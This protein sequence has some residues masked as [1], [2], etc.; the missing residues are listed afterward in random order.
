MMTIHHELRNE[1]YDNIP[2]KKELSLVYS[3]IP[4]ENLDELKILICQAISIYG[5]DCSLNWIDTSKVTDMSSLFSDFSEKY[6]IFNNKI[7]F[8]MFTGDISCWNVSNVKNFKKMF[9]GNKFFN[10]PLSWNMENAEDTS[11]MFYS[12]VFNKPIQWYFTKLRNAS[13]MFGFSK[14]D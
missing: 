13:H 1:D 9:Y 7:H 3:V 4:V 8:D 10:R 5:Y 2:S 6:Y 14:F 11:Y 12:S